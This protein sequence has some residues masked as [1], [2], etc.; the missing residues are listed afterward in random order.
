M[1]DRSLMILLIFKESKIAMSPVWGFSPGP[2]LI[3][4]IV[5]EGKSIIQETSLESVFEL[6]SASTRLRQICCS[7]IDMQKGSLNKMKMF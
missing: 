6:R 4:F 1:T 2:R 7:A 3:Y 5:L